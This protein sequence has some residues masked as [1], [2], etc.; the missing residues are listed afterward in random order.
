[1][2]NLYSS[3]TGST[4]SSEKRVWKHFNKL[5]F[6][7]DECQDLELDAQVDGEYEIA[8]VA[9]DHVDQSSSLIINQQNNSV[10]NS[11]SPVQLAAVNNHNEIN[12]NHKKSTNKKRKMTN[13]QTSS[14]Y[15]NNFTDLNKSSLPLNNSFQ[16]Q[17]SE[18]DH[19]GH[20]IAASLRKFDPKKQETVKLK[21]QEVI[22]QYLA[23]D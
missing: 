23:E 8:I 21:I 16:L 18:E 3:V 14:T 1:M 4:N 13:N 7:K 5:M 19:F 17:L 12:T 6:L 9:E 22:V 11:R 20:L 2:R 15:N 10:D